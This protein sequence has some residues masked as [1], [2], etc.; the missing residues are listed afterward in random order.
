MP[1][2]ARKNIFSYFE[3]SSIPPI[4]DALTDRI[5]PATDLVAVIKARGVRLRKSGQQYK[6]RCPF[7]EEKTP[8]YMVIPAEHL[9]HCFGCD[10]A[11]DMIRLVELMDN[12]SFPKAVKR[13]NGHSVD[14]LPSAS[15][16]KSSYPKPP[17]VSPT[18]GAQLLT[19]RKIWEYSFGTYH[20]FD[21]VLSCEN[22]ISGRIAP[23]QL[24]YT[25]DANGNH[26]LGFRTINSLDS[27]IHRDYHW[28]RGS[29]VSPIRHP[30]QSSS[31]S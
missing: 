18:Q 23:G 12:V 27:G 9:W 14:R 16:K 28:I 7:H 20:G 31:L 22:E 25:H 1:N 11:G 6:G 19:R 17:V 30:L 3:G 29:L 4:P 8:S 2:V 10:A 13:L 5:K 24:E 15:R 26:G 21:L